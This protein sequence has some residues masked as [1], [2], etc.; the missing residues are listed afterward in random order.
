VTPGA[1]AEAAP[2][3]APASRVYAIGP[4]PPAAVRVLWPGGG[5]LARDPA[6][7]T[8]QGFDVV[9]PQPADIYRMVT[10]EQA[11]LAQLV[12]SAHTLANAPIWLSVPDR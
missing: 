5:G 2:Y 9:T 12:A 1:I 6:L 7:W 10:D 8:A 11:A 3:Y 4:A